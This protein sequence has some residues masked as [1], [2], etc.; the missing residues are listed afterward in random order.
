MSDREDD[1]NYRTGEAEEESA[2]DEGGEEQETEDEHEEVRVSTTVLGIS[3]SK[4]TTRVLRICVDRADV[5][6]AT[7]D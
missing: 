3:K 2:V 5:D 7:S 1:E 4:Q 6:L